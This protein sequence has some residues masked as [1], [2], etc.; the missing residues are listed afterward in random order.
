P[1]FYRARTHSA[2][3][4]QQHGKDPSATSNTAPAR[5]QHI[6]GEAA[7]HHRGII[8]IIVIII[9]I[10]IAVTPSPLSQGTAQQ[11]HYRRVIAIAVW[12]ES[13]SKRC[14]A[15]QHRGPH[16]LAASAG[17][18]HHAVALP[19]VNVQGDD[20][21][22]THTVAHTKRE[23]RISSIDDRGNN[24]DGPDRLATIDTHR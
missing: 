3:L 14:S 8:I 15:R 1:Q 10:I 9:V 5:A 2:Q 6:I 12:A 22:Y 7:I 21:V 17:R 11:Q 23:L 4:Q 19:P 18:V 16:I 20:I 13:S 24:I